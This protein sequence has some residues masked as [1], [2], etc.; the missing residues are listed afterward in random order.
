MISA[1]HLWAVLAAPACGLF[2]VEAG[3]SVTFGETRASDD[4]A[5]PEAAHT[6]VRAVAPPGP[7]QRW[8][9][10]FLVAGATLLA[11]LGAPSSLTACGDVILCA[12][13]GHLAIVDLRFMVIPVRLTLVLAVVGLVFSGLTLGWTAVLWRGVFAMA[14]WGA[15]RALDRLY[16]W[17]RGRSG[18]GAGDALIASVITAWL[19]PERLAWSVASGCLLS[20]GFITIKSRG[21]TAGS[22]QAFAL[23]PGLATGAL[24]VLV[25]T[26]NG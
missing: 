3:L 24:I 16:Q 9:L 15:F 11:A 22:G 23:A 18:L 12:G 10:A 20:L 2:A 1:V 21:R 26:Q 6:M 5:A 17:A 13:L 8:G 4:V 14:A 7:G 25:A 19:G